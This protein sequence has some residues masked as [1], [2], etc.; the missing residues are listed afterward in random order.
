MTWHP[1]TSKIG[2]WMC[3]HVLE[4]QAKYM[5]YCPCKCLSYML[6]SFWN[7]LHVTESSYQRHEHW[8]DFQD[9]K[10]AKHLWKTPRQVWTSIVWVLILL[11]NCYGTGHHVFAAVLQEHAANSTGCVTNSWWP[12][13]EWLLSHTPYSPDLA[14]KMKLKSKVKQFN[15][16]LHVHWN[17]QQVLKGNTKEDFQW[18]HK[19]RVWFTNYMESRD[20]PWVM[21]DMTWANLTMDKHYQK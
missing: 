5:K 3:V 15:D 8:G 9:W 16:I 13:T 4:W 6:K 7:T 12:E 2:W 11:L 18:Q 10:M 21:Q 17:F 20:P 14:L 19:T 1:H